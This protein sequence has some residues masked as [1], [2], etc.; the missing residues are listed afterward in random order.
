MDF[1]KKISRFV[2]SLGQLYLTHVF[3]YERRALLYKYV[4]GTDFKNVVVEK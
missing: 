4:D 1:I 3:I 2:Q